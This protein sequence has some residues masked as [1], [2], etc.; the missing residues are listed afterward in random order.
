MIIPLYRRYKTIRSPDHVSRSI[1]VGANPRASL[2]ENLYL[3]GAQPVDISIGVDLSPKIETVIPKILDRA[4]LI[5][6]QWNLIN[7]K[8]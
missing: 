8:D 1:G 2:P 7:Y 4:D 3:I 5:L 6:Q